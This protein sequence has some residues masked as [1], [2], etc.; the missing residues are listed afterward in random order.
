MYEKVN[1]PEEGKKIEYRD[2]KLVVPDNPII[3]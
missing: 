1:P 3:P 2:G